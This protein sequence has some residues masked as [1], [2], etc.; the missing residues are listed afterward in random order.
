[1]FGYKDKA[2][3]KEIEVTSIL[4]AKAIFNMLFLFSKSF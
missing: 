2:V 3:V 4:K 1:M